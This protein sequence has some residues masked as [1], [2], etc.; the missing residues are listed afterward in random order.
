MSEWLEANVE[1]KHAAVYAVVGKDGTFNFVG[2]SRNVALTLAGHVKD[3]GQ[4]KV[5]QVKVRLS[6]RDAMDA[7]QILNSNNA[8]RTSA[9]EVTSIVICDPTSFQV[10]SFKYPKRDI[11]GAMQEEWIRECGY[12]PEGNLPGR[13]WATSLRDVQASV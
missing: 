12:I 10:R 6:E 4:D 2:V 5:Y 9:S 8:P 1:S 13:E 7:T 3:Q 11:M